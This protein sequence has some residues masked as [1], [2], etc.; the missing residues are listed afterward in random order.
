MLVQIKAIALIIGLTVLSG[1]ADS[2]GFMHAARIWEGKH[3]IWPEVL[4]SGLGFGAG[5]ILYWIVLKYL[6]VHIAAPEMQTLI[7]FGVTIVGVAVASGKFAQS[8]PIEQFVAVGV[9]LGIA[10]LMVRTSG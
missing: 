9:V 4:K 8:R 2:R 3:V 7:W 1:F 6:V 10:W 5:I